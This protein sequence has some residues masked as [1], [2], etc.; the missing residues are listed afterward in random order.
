MPCTRPVSG[1]RRSGSRGGFDE[2]LKFK[3]LKN[4]RVHK[5]SRFTGHASRASA[6]GRRRSARKAQP[7]PG[8]LGGLSRGG[9]G[10]TL[11][12]R[13]CRRS[14]PRGAP[15]QVSGSRMGAAHR[16]GRAGSLRAKPGS[17]PA[18]CGCAADV[19]GNARRKSG[20]RQVSVAS[21]VTLL[22]H[23]E[24]WVQK[25]RD[26]DVL[27][28][29]ETQLAHTWTPVRRRRS[30]AHGRGIGRNSRRCAGPAGTTISDATAGRHDPRHLAQRTVVVGDVLEQVGADNRIDGCIAD[31]KRACIGLQQTRRGHEPV[32]FAQTC[33]DQVSANQQRVWMGMMEVL[34][35][36]S[37]GASDVSDRR[38][39]RK[40]SDPSDD[41]AA[42][43][44]IDEM[45]A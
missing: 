27:Q 2:I 32:G 38:L 12:S 5:R 17:R 1:R 40:G 31:R 7:A 3:V 34:E 14:E 8:W 42:G 26:M 21:A 4:L 25:R 15:P 35:Q 10:G 22:D 30:G 39:G 6:G 19:G 37:G 18:S 28:R 36:V 44:A 16:R 24:R 29:L 9:G 43:L 13:G 45:S 41:R 11:V 33:S 20:A 23:P